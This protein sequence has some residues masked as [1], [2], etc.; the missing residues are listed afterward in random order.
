LI[1]RITAAYDRFVQAGTIINQTLNNE[2]KHWRQQKNYL[3]NPQALPGWIQDKVIPVYTVTS[4]TYCKSIPGFVDFLPEDQA[5]LIRMG[6]SPSRILVACI[7]WYDPDHDD[8]HNF[9][10]WRTDL[11]K[12]KLIVV[13]QKIHS[14]DI[15]HI[16]AAI[17][18]VLVLI[19]TDYPGLKNPSVISDL[20]MDMLGAFRAYTT[21]KLG[22]P[23]R[24]I[25]MLFSYITEIRELGMLHYKMTLTPTLRAED[26]NNI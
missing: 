25:E 12:K 17:L 18:N 1:N 3:D 6:Q 16:E 15:D 5:T 20:R 24:R 8:F 7:H 13:A 26:L 11:F 2:L 14:L 10:S 4:I 22:T 23:N 19:A 9:L 21:A